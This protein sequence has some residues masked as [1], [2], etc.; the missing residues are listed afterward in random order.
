M[1]RKNV[2]KTFV[3]HF[4]GTV[5]DIRF[6]DTHGPIQGTVGSR[7]FGTEPILGLLPYIFDCLD[8]KRS[9]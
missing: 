4:L 5:V 9:T 6:R 7:T 2:T 8:C 3:I 1:K